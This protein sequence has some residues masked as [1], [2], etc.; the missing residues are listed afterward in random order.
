MFRP[1]TT[2]RKPLNS[3]H[4][5]QL[6]CTV[7]LSRASAS[8]GPWCQGPAL[9]TPLFAL[10]VSLRLISRA[11]SQKK[12]KTRWGKG[13]GDWLPAGICWRHSI[14]TSVHHHIWYNDLQ[15]AMAITLLPPSK[16]HQRVS[17]MANSKW[18]HTGK[19]CWNSSTST[20]SDQNTSH[21]C[22]QEATLRKWA[23][24]NK[25]ENVPTTGRLR[26]E[27]PD[28]GNDLSKGSSSRSRK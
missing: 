16:F 20:N 8:W 24:M 5:T 7:Q 12:A 15:R 3:S 13:R 1:S 22:G 14:S 4:L 9:H 23:L 2:S 18:N 27:L 21:L 6:C 19:Q 26:Q 17:L 11:R 28:R 25:D 10:R